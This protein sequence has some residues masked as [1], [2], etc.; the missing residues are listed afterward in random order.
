[1]I[2]RVRM[3]IGRQNHEGRKMVV[4]LLLLG[5]SLKHPSTMMSD[6]SLKTQSPVRSLVQDKPHL[7]E[8]RKMDMFPDRSS[9][10]PVF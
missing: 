6:H 3:R 8:N 7:L 1:M 5:G 4:S 10:V 9:T 2:Q